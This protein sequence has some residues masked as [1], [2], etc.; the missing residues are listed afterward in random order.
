MVG[1]AQD[2]WLFVHAK[3]WGNATHAGLL[4]LLSWAARWK[5]WLGDRPVN[6]GCW[7]WFSRAMPEGPSKSIPSFLRISTE[8]KA[9]PTSINAVVLGPPILESFTPSNFSC[10]AELFRTPLPYHRGDTPPFS[11]TLATHLIKVLICVFKR[12]LCISEYWILEDLLPLKA[13]R[14][15]PC[16]SI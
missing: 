14:E 7:L 12:F 2:I 11:R 13:E 6:K 5:N 10:V 1:A 3:L 8:C 15:G 16:R 9:G 4:F